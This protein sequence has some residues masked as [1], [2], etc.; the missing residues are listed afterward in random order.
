M[1]IEDLGKEYWRIVEEGVEEAEVQ[2]G[3]LDTG[4]CGSG[5]PQSG[6]ILITV[7]CP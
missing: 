1:T 6:G 7:N 2:H 3:V 5:F 4:S